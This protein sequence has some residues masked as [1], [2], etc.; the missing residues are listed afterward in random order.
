MLDVLD[1][2]SKRLVWRG[3]TTELLNQDN[4]S[5]KSVQDAVK[6]IFDKFGH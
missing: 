6:N 1:A 3:W 2:Q 4:Y 5:D